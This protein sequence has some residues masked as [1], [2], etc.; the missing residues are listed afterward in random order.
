MNP[1]TIRRHV[2]YGLVSRWFERRWVFASLGSETHGQGSWSFA[3]T[4]RWLIN[5]QERS[6]NSTTCYSNHSYY[7]RA[8]K[9]PKFPL[10]AWWRTYLENDDP[11]LKPSWAIVLLLWAIFLDEARVIS[12]FRYRQCQ[13]STA[14][15][16]AVLT[17]RRSQSNISTLIKSCKSKIFRCRPIR[18]NFE[19]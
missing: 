11:V 9:I 6:L 19:L 5:W 3:I 17:Y 14:S 4:G 16:L 7:D 8:E 18:Q 1:K 10:M 2:N 13:S 12:E 15:K